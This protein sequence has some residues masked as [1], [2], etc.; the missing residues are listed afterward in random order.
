MEPIATV[1]VAGRVALV[2][3]DF[4]FTLIAPLLVPGTALRV[5]VPVDDNVPYTVVG[6]IVRLTTWNGLTV[7]TADLVTELTVAVRVVVL[8]AETLRWVTAKL[9][10]ED[11]AGIVNDARTVA[12]V[13]FELTRV[14]FAPPAGAG[15]LRVTMPVTS[16]CDPPTTEL[17]LRTT[18][19]S[20]GA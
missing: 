17:L 9:A 7:S 20:E 19:V 8:V 18:P 11:P 6:L 5:T 2:V 4:S 10:E 1:T 16:V 14:T 13:L 15:P 3:E 12:A